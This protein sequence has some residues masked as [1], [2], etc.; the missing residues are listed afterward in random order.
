MSTAPSRRRNERGSVLLEFALCAIFM[1]TLIFGIIEF[2]LGWQD[3]LTVQTAS[4]AGVRVGSNLTTNSQADYNILQTV[5]SA[6]NDVG[7]SNV[8]AVVIYKSTTA[9]GLVPAACVA[10]TVKSVALTCNA[11]SG[12]QLQTMTSADFG[13]GVG[14]LDLSWCPTTRQNLQA[15][16]PDYL[17]VWI[18]MTHHN[19]T[20]MFGTNYKI[21]DSSVMRLEPLT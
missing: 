20:G 16:G 4:R 8:D 19:I 5:R 21:T 10:P 14:D 1:I 17:G 2:G 15:V 9:D 12:A 6:I 11:Y 18:R 13:C 7:L 3:R